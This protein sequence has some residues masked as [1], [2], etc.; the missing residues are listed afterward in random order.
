MEKLAERDPTDE[1]SKAFTLFDDDSTGKITCARHLILRPLHLPNAQVQRQSRACAR[2]AAGS[3]SFDHARHDS[4]PLVPLRCLRRLLHRLRNLR[5]VARELGEE[6]SDDE[7]LAM[8]AEFDRARG[9]HRDPAAVGCACA[10]CTPAARAEIRT[11]IKL[12]AC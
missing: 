9:A 1:M 6:V 3:R 7:L 2:A 10:Q 5:R 8:I 4:Q 11:T 12:S